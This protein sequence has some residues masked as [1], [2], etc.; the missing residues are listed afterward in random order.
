MPNHCA[1]DTVHAVGLIVVAVTNTLMLC[2]IFYFFTAV[3]K[4]LQKRTGL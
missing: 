1:G 4:L 3:L 2:I